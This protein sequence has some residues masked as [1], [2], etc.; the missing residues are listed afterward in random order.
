MFEFQIPAMS[1][2]H[3]VT[4]VTQAVQEVDGAAWVDVDL[5]AKQIRVQPGDTVVAEADT[6]RR[7]FAEAL[8]EAGYPPVVA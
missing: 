3:C 6:L 8:S 7:R 1:C 2:D 5:P 4:T